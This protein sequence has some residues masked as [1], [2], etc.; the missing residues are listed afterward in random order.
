MKALHFIAERQAGKLC[1]TIFM[2]FG[3]T[4]MGIEPEST[5]SVADAISTNL[6]LC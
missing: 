5:I 1:I 2:V 3:L 6:T 4:Q